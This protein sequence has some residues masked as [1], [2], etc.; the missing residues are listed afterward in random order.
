[1]SNVTC[2]HEDGRWNV[3][4][5]KKWLGVVEVVGVTIVECDDDS[6]VRELSIL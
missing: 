2:G 1:M 4:A 3:I 6:P 5:L